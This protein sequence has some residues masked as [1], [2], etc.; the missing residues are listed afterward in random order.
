[1]G[2]GVRHSRRPWAVACASVRSGVYSPVGGPATCQVLMLR[3]AESKLMPRAGKR[4]QKEQA[5]I[6]I[7]P[8]AGPLRSQRLRENIPHPRSL[9]FI[10]GPILLATDAR[11][12]TRIGSGSGLFTPPFSSRKVFFIF[13]HRAHR[14]HRGQARGMLHGGWGHEESM[15]ISL[16]KPQSPP[17]PCR[18]QDK[19]DN[20][21]DR[22]FFAIFAV[23]SE[24]G[25]RQFLGPGGGK[26]EEF[27]TQS[28]PSPPRPCGR[29]GQGNN[30]ANWL[31]LAIF[32]S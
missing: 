18:R 28:S 14:E 23:L 27:L 4:G 13:Y 24:A 31:R 20:A 22:L 3:W 9:A 8:P 6:S 29:K 30:A 26:A 7:L 10:R 32:A 11:G 19:E 5:S 25:V 2:S 21:A 15:K 12:C 1:M 17:R 16:A